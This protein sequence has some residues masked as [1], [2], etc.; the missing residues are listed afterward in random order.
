MQQTRRNMPP[1]QPG[2]GQQAAA[3]NQQ[4]AAGKPVAAAAV[5][6]PLHKG[7]HRR[8]GQKIRQR[9]G[10]GQQQLLRSRRQMPS[11]EISSSGQ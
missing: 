9:P 6:C 1:V 3:A 5:P 2:Q 4:I 7:K 10:G 8:A 11:G